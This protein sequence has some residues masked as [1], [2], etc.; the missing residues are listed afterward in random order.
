MLQLRDRTQVAA[1][2]Q[3]DVRIA[4]LVQGIA[5]RE[6]PV[7]VV[8]VV[9]LDRVDTGLLP[10]AI[11]LQLGVQLLQAVLGHEFAD[12]AVFPVVKPPECGVE[13]VHDHGL[14]RALHVENDG[15][16]GGGGH[17]LAELLRRDGRRRWLA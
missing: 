12:V 15:K 10:L 8:E 4:G 13:R 6:F 11:G 3:D 17:D 16:I 5:D 2:H 7:R 1:K 14:Y 9:D